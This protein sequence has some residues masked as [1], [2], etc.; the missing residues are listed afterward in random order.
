MTA[1]DAGSA[2]VLSEQDKRKKFVKAT[3]MV[4][5]VAFS[6]LGAGTMYALLAP[7]FPAEVGL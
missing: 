6:C 5:S 3:L 4:S 1:G 7:F 2:P